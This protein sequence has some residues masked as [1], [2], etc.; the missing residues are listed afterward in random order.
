MKRTLFALALAAALPMSAQA[1]E[2]S[3]SYVEL[4]YVNAEFD[5]GSSLN[6]D[7][8]G[9][10]VRG[11]VEFAD[12]GFYGFGS[13]SDVEDLKQTD[14]GLGYAHN[15]SDNV[16]LVAELAWRNT[17]AGS[18]DADD[19]RVSVGFRGNLADNFEGSIKANYIDG[20]AYDSQF[21]ATVGGQFKFNDTWGITG[22]AE[23][24]DDVTIYSVGVRASF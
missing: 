16:D 10:G 18:F 20:D 2:R 21:G 19:T 24:V 5:L 15:L 12:S 8:D 4:D 6:V 1:A 3:Y 22:E 14:L 11:S 7:V 13:Y 9:V 23:F 17:D